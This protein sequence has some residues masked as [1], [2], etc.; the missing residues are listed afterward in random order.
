[1]KKLFVLLW[2]VMAAACTATPTNE[3]LQGIDEKEIQL[4][5]RGEVED[6]PEGVDN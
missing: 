1:M 6:P 3:E 4:I 2:V 5:D